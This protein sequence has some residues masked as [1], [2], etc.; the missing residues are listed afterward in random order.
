[1]YKIISKDIVSRLSSEYS[2]CR[3]IPIFIIYRL[4]IYVVKNYNKPCVIYD[5]ITVDYS[6]KGSRSHSGRYNCKNSI[7]VL[8]K[9]KSSKLPPHT[10]I[11]TPIHTYIHTYIV[12]VFLLT[13][14]NLYISTNH[15][16]IQLLVCLISVNNSKLT[17]ILR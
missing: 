14:T 5:A 1:M 11:Y 9:Y 3:T 12:R 13:F 2:L 16:P 17:P 10:H 6:S 8:Q 15:H 7:S 4:Y